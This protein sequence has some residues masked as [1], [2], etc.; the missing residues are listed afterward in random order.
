MYR[1]ENKLALAVHATRN[2]I[3]RPY[4]QANKIE[5]NIQSAL[6]LSL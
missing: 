5:L 4:V 6:A 2:T 3:A 1:K